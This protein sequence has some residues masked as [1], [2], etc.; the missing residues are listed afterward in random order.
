[1]V[2]VDL[3]IYCRQNTR[4]QWHPT[5]IC[6]L[7]LISNLKSE[8]NLK[9]IEKD[10]RRGMYIYVA[11]TNVYYNESNDLFSIFYGEEIKATKV[12]VA[13]VMIIKFVWQFMLIA[14]NLRLRFVAF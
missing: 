3:M 14:T 13:S 11:F 12:C 6:S 9:F 4:D 10:A 8:A 1:M 5:I 7:N 2:L